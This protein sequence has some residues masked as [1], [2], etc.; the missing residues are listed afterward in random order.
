[1]GDDRRVGVEGEERL[2]EVDG[3]LRGGKEGPGGRRDAALRGPDDAALRAARARLVVTLAGETAT[4]APDRAGERA[5]WGRAREP[6]RI[7]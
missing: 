3:V 1:V 2:A 6:G 4:I 5:R 7:S